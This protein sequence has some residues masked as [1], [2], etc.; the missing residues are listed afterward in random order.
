MRS[1]DR[2]LCFSLSKSSRPPTQKLLGA[3]QP[4]RASRVSTWEAI[5][6]ISHHFCVLGSGYVFHFFTCSHWKKT[7][8]IVNYNHCITENSCPHIHVNACDIQSI[9]T[10]FF[11]WKGSWYLCS[12]RKKHFMQS[13][14][15]IFSVHFN[16]CQSKGR[17]SE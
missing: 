15:N 11:L 16:Y 12:G 2:V 4:W 3:R 14:T 1:A 5:I 10:S 6:N 8:T 17:K 13:A 9:V 7:V